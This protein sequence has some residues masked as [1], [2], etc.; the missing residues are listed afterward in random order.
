MSSRPIWTV[1][2]IPSEK[3]K[4]R[5]R[6]VLWIL[7]GIEWKEPSPINHLSFKYIYIYIHI[8]VYIY[9]MNVWSPHPKLS[10]FFLFLLSW[11][12]CVNIDV[13]TVL[14]R[15]WLNTGNISVVESPSS[16]EENVS[17]QMCKWVLG[18]QFWHSVYHGGVEAYRRKQ[19]E[20]ETSA[21]VGV[22]QM[23]AEWLWYTRMWGL[24][25]YCQYFWLDLPYLP[26][27]LVT[28]IQTVSRGCY[29]YS[30]D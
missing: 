9:K 17:R 14:Y 28:Y 10:G 20:V 4:V 27:L 21:G 29:I 7:G 3:Q 30:V 18:S 24:Q 22:S 2:Q 15:H 1:Y 26:L 16:P 13:H 6:K 8:Y 12:V 23:L 11:F 19:T 5:N 25:S